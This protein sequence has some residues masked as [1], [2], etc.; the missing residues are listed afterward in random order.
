VHQTLVHFSRML[1]KSE[2]R[3][4]TL[5]APKCHDAVSAACGAA[6]V[7]E[8]FLTNLLLLQCEEAHPG[9]RMRLMV[10]ARDLLCPLHR[11]RDRVTGELLSVRRDYL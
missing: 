1:K 2:N 3:L 11:N 10:V 6:T 5:A 9:C 4:L 7:R 8:R